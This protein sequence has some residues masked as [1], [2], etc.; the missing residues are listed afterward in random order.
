MLSLVALSLALAADP[1]LAEELNKLIPGATGI[2]LVEVIDMKETNALPIDGNH[3][4]NVRFKVV[5]SSG[6][7]RDF[8]HVIIRLG[9][10][11]ERVPLDG[12]IKPD[13][14]KQGQR[15]WVAFASQDDFKKYPH[16]LVNAWPEKDAPKIILEA[17]KAQQFGK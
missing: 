4:I 3:F 5:E 7:V 1:K 12:P 10:F 6:K 17:A 11:R 16:G 2:A 14:F 15:Y 13:T 8:D 9:G